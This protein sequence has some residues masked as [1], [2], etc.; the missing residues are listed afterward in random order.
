M[1]LTV[2]S[3]KPGSVDRLPASSVA[4]V[5]G[6]RGQRILADKVHRRIG[7]VAEQLR[8]KAAFVELEHCVGV[9]PARAMAGLGPAKNGAFGPVAAGF[10]NHCGFGLA[11]FP[12]RFHKFAH[13]SEAEAG[14]A[15]HAFARRLGMH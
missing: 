3:C 9:A 11:H 10:R 1:P 14:D 6:G 5:V 12:V 8:L 15:R 13:W 2:N 4:G 7:H